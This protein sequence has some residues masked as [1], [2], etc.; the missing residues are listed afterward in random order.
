MDKAIDLVAGTVYQN[1]SYITRP[2]LYTEKGIESCQEL[3]L[4]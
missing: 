1:P 3:S 4:E 2:E